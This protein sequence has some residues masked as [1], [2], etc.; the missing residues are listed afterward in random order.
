[1]N[2]NDGLLPL[3]RQV[4]QLNKIKVI[5]LNRKREKLALYYVSLITIDLKEDNHLA[6]KRALIE[7]NINLIRLERN[8]S[9]EW[10][11]NFAK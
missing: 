2:S 1:M 9:L 7:T 8:E 6:T 4:M 3:I 10:D 11:F 5:V